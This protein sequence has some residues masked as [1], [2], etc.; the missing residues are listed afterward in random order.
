MARGIALAVLGVGL[1]AGMAYLIWV[2]PDRQPCGALCWRQI[3]VATT[4]RGAP[5]SSLDQRQP[6][7]EAPAHEHTPGPESHERFAMNLL[8]VLTTVVFL[9]RSAVHV[10]WA[11]GGRRGIG[12]AIPTV[13]GRRTLNP[14][15]LATIAVAAALAVAAAITIGSTGVLN[16]LAPAWLIRS[17]LIVLSVVFLVRAVGDFRLIGF[18]KRVK[19]TRFARLDTRVFVPLC[20]GLAAACA[21]LAWLAGA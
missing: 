5:A 14:S 6:D 12:A 19:D 21:A 10:Y 15:P 11:F 17:G 8:A 2:S 20:V 4:E 9:G 16:S 7:R 3:K 13:E 18:T 1:A